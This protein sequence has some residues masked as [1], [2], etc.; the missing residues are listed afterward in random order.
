MSIREKKGL[1][2][3]PPAPLEPPRPPRQ[4]K[5][6]PEHWIPFIKAEDAKWKA[7]QGFKMRCDHCGTIRTQLGKCSWC[8]TPQ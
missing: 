1:A 3:L 2:D 7:L 4:P 8:G 6:I 5:S